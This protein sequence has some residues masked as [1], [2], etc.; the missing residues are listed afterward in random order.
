MHE[1]F[2]R[3]D[4]QL[5]DAKPSPLSR[6]FSSECIKDSIS[7]ST[8]GEHGHDVIWFNNSCSMGR[9]HAIVA[10]DRDN[11]RVGIKNCVLNCLFKGMI[12]DRGLGFDSYIDDICF[13]SEANDVCYF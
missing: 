5:I 13:T 3:R 12:Y 9:Q 4:C 10:F 8:L 7:V 6:F 2:E 11:Q 1:P